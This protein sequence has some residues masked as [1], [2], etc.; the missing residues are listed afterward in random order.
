M[1]RM[2]AEAGVQGARGGRV[3]GEGAKTLRP[4]SGRSETDMVLKI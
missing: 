3:T 1:E 4:T 2:K